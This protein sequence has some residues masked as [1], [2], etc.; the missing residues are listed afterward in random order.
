[1]DEIDEA[2]SD[3]DDTFSPHFGDVWRTWHVDDLDLESD[4]TAEEGCKEEEKKL[5]S[6]SGFSSSLLSLA[7]CNA[8][9]ASQNYSSHPWQFIF[10]FFPAAQLSVNSRALKFLQ[11]V[12]DS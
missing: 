2:L 6:K 8:I 3:M 5:A 1:M 10:S 9:S 11:E 7:S 4:E 12:S